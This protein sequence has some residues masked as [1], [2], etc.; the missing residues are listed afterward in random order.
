VHGTEEETENSA[1]CLWLVTNSKPC[2]NC[3]SPIQKN[4][5]CNHMKCSKVHFASFH[6]FYCC[7]TFIILAFVL[8][9]LLNFVDMFIYYHF[10]YHESWNC[11]VFSRIVLW[12]V[13]V[14]ACCK[15]N[16]HVVLVSFSTVSVLCGT[17]STDLVIV[18]SSAV[19]I[20]EI[21]DRID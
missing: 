3:K 14:D 10:C 20:F 6:Q 9:D 17:I 2:P 4:E 1:N 8:S 12:L 5:G 15:S 19:Q 16:Q 18:F 7:P 11:S 21:L 13:Y